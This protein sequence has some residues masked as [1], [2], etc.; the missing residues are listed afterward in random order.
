[1]DYLLF[2]QLGHTFGMSNLPVD[3]HKIFN[4]DKDLSISKKCLSSIQEYPVKLPNATGFP[5]QLE[6]SI[7]SGGG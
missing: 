2:T 4:E 6:R 3:K 7:L 1:M 5:S